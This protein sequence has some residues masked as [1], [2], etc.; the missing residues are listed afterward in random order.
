MHHL[1]DNLQPS[2]AISEDDYVLW[3]YRLL[4]GRE[5]EPKAIEENSY[6]HDTMLLVDSILNSEEFHARFTPERA[7]PERNPFATWTRDAIA[8][9]HLPKTGGTTLRNLLGAHFP[10]DRICPQAYNGLHLYKAADLAQYDFFAGHFDAFALHF[11]PRRDVRCISLFR[12]PVARLISWY[13]FC[14]AH[15]RSGHYIEEQFIRMAH[16]LTVEEFFEHDYAIHSP[17]HNNAYLFFLGSSL[18]DQHTLQALTRSASATPDGTMDQVHET[19]APVL[20]QALIQVQRL[21]A[22]G[23]S[24]RFGPSVRLIFRTLGL[25][26]PD[27]IVSARVTDD[28]ATM[29]PRFSRVPPVQMTPRLARALDRLTQYDQVIYDAAKRR[30]DQLLRET[31]ADP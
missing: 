12:D 19:V 18:D 16:D 14:R 20:A 5:P 25:P 9:L 6:K 3:A 4:L 7:L 30:F 26:Q 2:Q 27:N 11:I 22:L 23:L 21:D 8:F 17:Y 28:L 15:P 10:A 13:R 1:E 24:E 31:S 29:D